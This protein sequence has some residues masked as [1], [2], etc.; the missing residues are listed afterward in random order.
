MWRRGA[1]RDWK[2]TACPPCL[3]QNGAESGMEREEM[4]PFIFLF[5]FQRKNPALQ[6]EM[7][8]LPA[9]RDAPGF[10]S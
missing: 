10:E 9:R 5:A 6:R 4:F 3:V 2:N 7:G 1:R 8:N